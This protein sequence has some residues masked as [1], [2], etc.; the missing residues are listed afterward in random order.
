MKISRF[1]LVALVA[2]LALTPAVWAADAT[3]VAADTWAAIK[4]DTYQQRRDFAAGA[5]RLLAKLDE[6]IRKLNEKRATLPET[7]VKDWDTAM[8]AVSAERTY[9]QS[10]ISALDEATSETW[11]Q[12]KERV[13]G[14]WQRS[15]DA[16]DKVQA[17]TT[18]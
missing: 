8:N 16:C 10:M 7:S 9:L 11:S 18:T 4:D 13:G 12:A 3:P 2:L 6:Q 5:S 15:Q 17:S 1:P 14:S